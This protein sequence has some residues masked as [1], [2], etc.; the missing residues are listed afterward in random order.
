MYSNCISNLPFSAQAIFEVVL[1]NSP[2]APENL[3]FRIIL[4]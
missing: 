3:L 4:W 2:D 1:K